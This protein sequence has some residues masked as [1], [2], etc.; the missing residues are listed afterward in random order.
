ML[1]KLITNGLW[2]NT[3][4]EKFFLIIIFLQ[5]RVYTNDET[6]VEYREK[7]NKTDGA[8]KRELTMKFAKEIKA[9]RS[10]RER[11]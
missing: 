11:E 7:Y 4:F 8:M 10:K 9:L 5:N 1:E 6:D 2:Y 3:Y